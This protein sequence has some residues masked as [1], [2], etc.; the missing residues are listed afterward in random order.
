MLGRGKQVSL[1]TV[2]LV[3][4]VVRLTISEYRRKGWVPHKLMS[5]EIVQQAVGSP[6]RVLVPVFMVHNLA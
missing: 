1:S 5:L 6:C 4:M 3:G 2:D